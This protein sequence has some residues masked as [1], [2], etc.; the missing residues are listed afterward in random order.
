MNT[1]SGGGDSRSF[2]PLE[3]RWKHFDI[4]IRS[5]GGCKKHAPRQ[6]TPRGS[7][8]RQ[9]VNQ[10]VSRCPQ[11]FTH[12]KNSTSQFDNIW[13]LKFWIF[14]K[15]D[16]STDRVLLCTTSSVSHG[17]FAFLH[18]VPLKKK[19]TNQK[20]TSTY[21]FSLS[22][23]TE[24]VAPWIN[25]SCAV[26]RT[27]SRHVFKFGRVEGEEAHGV[28]CTQILLFRKGYTGAKNR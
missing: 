15:G 5:C 1:I 14:G 28:W 7:F 27:N 6:E 17:F 23:S 4:S 18:N 8:G 12:N 9:L 25:F 13:T 26:R 16:L 10:S 19:V 22:A 20:T 11:N 21:T 3:T 2:I 24:Y